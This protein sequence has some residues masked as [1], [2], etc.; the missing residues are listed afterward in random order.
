MPVEPPALADTVEL[1]DDL[2]AEMLPL[3]SMPVWDRNDVGSA[4]LPNLGAIKMM[5]PAWNKWFD[6]CFQTCLWLGTA[7]PSKKS[8]EKQLDRIR[9][10]GAT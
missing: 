10:N 6:G 2:W 5:N 3:E 7:Q 4:F 1:G 8:Q 9:G